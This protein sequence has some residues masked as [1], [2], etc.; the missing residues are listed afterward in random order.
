MRRSIRLCK[1]KFCGTTI[2]IVVYG[3]RG[4]FCRS[5]LCG[6]GAWVFHDRSVIGQDV[7]VCACVCACVCVCLCVRV[8]LCVF[9]CVFVCVVC[10]Y[11][12]CVWL[13]VCCC[14]C[15]CV[16]VCV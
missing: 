7:C 6:R 10:V 12:L 15:V 14:V 9:V 11:V 1:G 4:F 3:L 8:C 16:G 5:F 2:F 13:C